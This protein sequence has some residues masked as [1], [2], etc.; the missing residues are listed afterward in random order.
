MN[1]FLNS[2]MGRL[3]SA[4]QDLETRFA[5]MAAVADSLGILEWDS[6]TTMPSGAAAGRAEQTATLHLVLHGMQTDPRLKELLDQAETEAAMLDPWQMANLR[7]M[8]RLWRHTVTVPADLVEASSR[9]VSACE[10]MW[11]SARPNNDFAALSPLLNNVLRLKREIGQAK[12]EAFGCSPYEALLEDYEPGARIVDLDRLFDSL[13]T[14]LPNF[15]QS[16]LERQA[17]LPPIEPLVGP[18]PIEFQ[19][20]LGECLM[21]ALGFDFSR[22]RLDVSLHP[23]CG[24]ARDD[25]RITT[26]YNE[27]DFLPALMG[28][29]H[30]TGHAL[31]E[32]NRPAEWLNQPVGAARGMSIH[33]SQSLLIEMQ[34]C[35]SKAFMEFLAPLA[36]KCF[37]GSG[38]AWSEDA[39]WRRITRVERSFIRVDADEATYSAHVILRYRLEKAMVAGD[40]SVADLPGAWNE[41]FQTLLGVAPPD[42]RRGCLQDI[43]WPGGAWGYFPTYALGAMTAAQLFESARQSDSDVELGLSRGDFGPLIRWMRR[44]IHSQGCLLSTEMLLRQ[45]TGRPLAPEA[46][47]RHLERRYLSA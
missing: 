25:V 31:Y 37:G 22:G 23:F 11:R 46:Y 24:G 17:R 28:V 47:C 32:Q 14:F 10:I 3:M 15:I 5:R 26:R 16:A 39:L 1:N 6:Q 45:A 9:A 42:D 12:A 30:E 7:E 18:F 40:L 21:R 35:R 36:R 44:E 2:N 34:A 19:K 8:R 29:A 43:H 4:Y 41:M 27:E 38:A 33:E 13:A 20:A